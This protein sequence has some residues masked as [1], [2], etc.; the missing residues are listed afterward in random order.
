MGANIAIAYL[1]KAKHNIGGIISLYG[2][3]PLS[4]DNMNVQL[5]PKIPLL[6]I[7]NPML[8]NDQDIRITWKYT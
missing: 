1:L 5:S 4:N 8:L 3:N 6:M 7:N 2:M